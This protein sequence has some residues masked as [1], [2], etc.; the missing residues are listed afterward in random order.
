MIILKGYDKERE[1]WAVCRQYGFE[2]V[3][4]EIQ[5]LDEVKKEYDRQLKI[6]NHNRKQ[7]RRN[8]WKALFKGQKIQ[9]FPTM[10]KS[11]QEKI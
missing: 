10:G 6:F 11:R 9:R 3:I 2:K 8:R 7:E 5:P 1:V 4:I